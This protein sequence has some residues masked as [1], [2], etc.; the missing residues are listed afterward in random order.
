MCFMPRVLAWMPQHHHACMFKVSSSLHPISVIELCSLFVLLVIYPALQKHM[1]QPWKLHKDYI[2][3]LSN[4]MSWDSCLGQA[5][6]YWK[7]FSCIRSSRLNWGILCSWA[8]MQR[9]WNMW[10]LFTWDSGYI[11][12]LQPYIKYQV[13][14]I[15]KQVSCAIVCSRGTEELFANRFRHPEALLI[16]VSI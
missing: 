2:I 1:W 5:R 7:Y 15:P 6:W 10:S 3:A 4:C 11:Q 14:N 16:L 8:L 13:P 12:A 9:L